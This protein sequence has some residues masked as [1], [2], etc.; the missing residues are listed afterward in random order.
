MTAPVAKV[1]RRRRAPGP[2]TLP[3]VRILSRLTGRSVEDIYADRD[4]VALERLATA[5]ELRALARR[6]TR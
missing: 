4:A 6:V 3:E 2:G 5:R 1:R